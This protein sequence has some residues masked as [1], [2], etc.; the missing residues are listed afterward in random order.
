MEDRVRRACKHLLL[1]REDFKS[2]KPEVQASGRCMLLAVSA[3]L[4]EMADKMAGNGDVAVQSERRLYE[5]MALK[6]S[7]AS[8]NTDPAVVGE[9][10]A[11]LM[12]LRDSA[13]DKYA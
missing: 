10:H 12:E 9:V 3:L 2:D 5:F 7:I 11:L 8:E 1:A 6:L 13:A 4:V